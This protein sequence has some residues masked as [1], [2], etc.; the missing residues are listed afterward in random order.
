MSMD[1]I[2][3]FV[4]DV[5]HN[6]LLAGLLYWLPLAFCAFGYLMRTARNFRK[7]RGERTRPGAFYHPTDTI[8][9]LIGRAIVTLLPVGNLLAAIFDLGPEVFGKF[10]EWLRAVFDQPLVP[11]IPDGQEIRSKRAAEAIRRTPR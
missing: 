7:D 2:P 8:G 3:D 4:L 6:T 5:Y 11:D 10:F 9:S 1:Y